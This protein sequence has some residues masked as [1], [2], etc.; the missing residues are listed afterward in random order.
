MEFL[1]ELF[2]ESEAIQDSGGGNIIDLH[3]PKPSDFGLRMVG[4]TLIKRLIAFEDQ[5]S[6]GTL[7]DI[8]KL[9][10]LTR[11][12]CC[13]KDPETRKATVS[14]LL[15]WLATLPTIQREVFAL[16]LD[17][18]IH[19]QGSRLDTRLPAE[20]SDLLRGIIQYMPESAYGSATFR[21]DHL[22][23]LEGLEEKRQT[24]SS[25]TQL[26]HERPPL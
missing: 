12:L 13:P 23:N 19:R 14:E 24:N 26:K 3:R 4:E 7:R 6:P 11:I 17:D 10:R 21:Q 22:R 18:Y 2:R 5:L 9:T 16:Q 25:R 8:V 15:E 1:R 20:C